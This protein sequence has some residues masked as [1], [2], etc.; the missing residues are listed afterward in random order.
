VRD[1]PRAQRFFGE[2]LGWRFADDGRG[3]VTNISAPPGAVTDG[4]PD[5]TGARLWFVVDDL[6]A[7]VATVRTLGGTATEPAESPSGR[8]SDCTD[9]QG[10]VFSLSEPSPLYRR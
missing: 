9:D 6:A 2:L 4:Y 10:T 1:L 7:A 3:H 8:W 5:D